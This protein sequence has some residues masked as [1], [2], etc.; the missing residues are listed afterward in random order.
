MTKT[1]INA[2]LAALVAC[3]VAAGAASVSAPLRFS[4][5]QAERERAV[6][7]CLVRIRMAEEAYLRVH[8]TYTDDLSALVGEGFLADSLRWIPFSGGREFSVATTVVTGKSGRQVPLME[9]GAT[10]DEYL[11]GLD[12][13]G[14][15]DLVE[16]ATSMGEYPG[17]KIGDLAAP[18][19]NQGNWE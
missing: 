2:I 4:G 11:S 17:L 15:A 18:N 10:F 9:C 16:R 6:K 1:S 19:D 3:L 8:G 7:A 12:G 14:V 13:N 5:R